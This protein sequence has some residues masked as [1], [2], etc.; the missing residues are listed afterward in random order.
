[1]IET[2]NQLEYDQKC[3]CANAPI[4]GVDEKEEKGSSTEEGKKWEEKNASESP[5]FF[6]GKAP[7]RF[8]R[9]PPA[10]TWQPLLVFPSFF[11][12]FFFFLHGRGV[13]FF[14]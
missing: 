9:C 5:H 2:E 11:F 10:C 1:M 12:F 4:G 6:L 7:L 14:S 13:F 3:L 8:V